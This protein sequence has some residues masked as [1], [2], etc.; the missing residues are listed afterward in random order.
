MISK[1]IKNFVVTID[2]P[3]GAGKST[4]ARKVADDT[5]LQYLD[6]GAIYRAAAW[7]LDGRG[8]PARDCKELRDALT[9][10]S[11]SL[12]EGKVFVNGEDTAP[13]IRTPK[14]DRIASA[15]SAVAPLR[16][17]LLEV[18]REQAE[19]GL[20]AE[21]RDMGT[22]VFPD[23]DLKIFLTA[24]SE[25]RAMRRYRQRKARGEE[26]DYDEILRQVNERDA[27]DMA[28]EV[29]PLRP[30][31][32]AIILDSTSMSFEQVTDAIA[33]LVREFGAQAER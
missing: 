14:A 26:A 30:A 7:W 9:E 3:A 13:H 20:V 8:V 4:V 10:M 23:A 18:Q 29:A 12:K 32:G 25:E 31:Q 24:T 6:T 15:Y 16:D 11:I 33:S 28:R 17:A 5:G 2:G 21:G 22:V 19:R 1:G 27:N